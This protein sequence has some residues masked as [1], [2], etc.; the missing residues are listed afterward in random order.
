MFKN[1]SR[2]GRKAIITAVVLTAIAGVAIAAWQ[3]SKETTGTGMVLGT[4]ALSDLGDCGGY[5]VGEEGMCQ[6]TLTNQYDLD[7]LVLDVV[8]A[9]DRTDISTVHKVWEIVSGV[10]PVPPGGTIVVGQYWYP[11]AG[12]PPGPIAFSMVV[13]AAAD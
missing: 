1:F 3:L 11:E 12:A 2:I 6:T 4:F 7:V 8:L 13:E 10:N 9:A 5:I